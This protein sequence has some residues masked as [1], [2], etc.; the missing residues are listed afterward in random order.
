MANRSISKYNIHRK[1]I[2]TIW[3]CIRIQRK[4]LRNKLIDKRIEH[5]KEHNK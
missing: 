3:I 5:L 4:V 1:V 2:K